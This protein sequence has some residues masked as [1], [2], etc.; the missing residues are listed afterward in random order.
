MQREVPL[1]LMLYL[2]SMA[3]KQSRASQDLGG[4]RQRR[5]G[6]VAPLGGGSQEPAVEHGRPQFLSPTKSPG[7]RPQLVFF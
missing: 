4:G 5:P 6:S 1:L 3:I 7:R 2:D